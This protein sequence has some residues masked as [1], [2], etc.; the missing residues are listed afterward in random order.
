VATREHLTMRVPADVLRDIE[1]EARRNGRPVT[2]LAAELL[3]DGLVMRRYPGIH[4]RDGAG[5]RRP[6][7]IGHRLDVAHVVTT[8]RGE[9]DDIDRAAE[10]FNV[11]VGLIRSA[12]EYYADHTAEVDDWIAK[13]DEW[14]A[15]A[16]R[17]WR[18]G[19]SLIAE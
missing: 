15:E 13:E 12:M 2:S 18:N 19:Q 16:E 6:A 4:M 14:A 10:Y 8:M 11:P 9:G 5:G 7:L 3:A 17:R 1:R